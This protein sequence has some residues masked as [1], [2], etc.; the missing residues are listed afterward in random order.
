MIKLGRTDQSEADFLTISTGRVTAWASRQDKFM[1]QA[2]DD[3]LELLDEVIKGARLQ[4]FVFPDLPD[5]NR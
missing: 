5:H 2:T 3:P 1:I 4:S